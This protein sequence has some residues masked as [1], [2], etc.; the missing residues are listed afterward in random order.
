MFPLTVPEAKGRGYEPYGGQS[1]PS[2]SRGGQCSLAG[3]SGV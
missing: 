2:V 1:V 3:L